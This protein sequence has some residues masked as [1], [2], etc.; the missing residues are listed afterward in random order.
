MPRNVE[1]VGETV[2]YCPKFKA[3]ACTASDTCSSPAGRQGKCSLLVGGNSFSA[4]CAA[5]VALV[6]KRIARD[7]WED[8]VIAEI[9]KDVAR[10]DSRYH[11]APDLVREELSWVV[12][13]YY[14]AFKTPIP[15]A[16]CPT[17]TSANKEGHHECFEYDNQRQDCFNCMSAPAGSWKGSDVDNCCEVCAYKPFSHDNPGCQDCWY[18]PDDVATM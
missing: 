2:V 9:I 18:R 4:A 5:V 12:D 7:G 1:V 11:N 3:G 10:M 13:E 17:R 6:A 8:D 15:A 14:E 16:A